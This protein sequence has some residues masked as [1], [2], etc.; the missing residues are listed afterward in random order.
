[1]LG[2]F[3]LIVIF[4]VLLIFVA[5][6]VFYMIFKNE[7]TQFIDELKGN[8][9]LNSTIVEK[10]TVKKKHNKDIEANKHHNNDNL[11]K[12]GHKKDK[13]VHRLHKDDHKHKERKD[14][15]KAIPSKKNTDRKDKHEVKTKENKTKDKHKEKE[16]HK[17]RDKPKEK[18]KPVVKETPKKIPQPSP[19]ADKKP[20]PANIKQEQTSKAMGTRFGEPEGSESDKVVKHRGTEEFIPGQGNLQSTIPKPVSNVG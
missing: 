3:I 15:P 10:P 6:V 12:R 11:H 1:M 4:L 19:K 17:H 16:K 14:K 18:E 9:S 5:A 8:S 2:T 13:E 7:V 20:I